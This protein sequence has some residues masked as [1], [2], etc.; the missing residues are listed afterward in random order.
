LPFVINMNVQICP[1]IGWKTD[2]PFGGNIRLF[3]CIT[4]WKSNNNFVG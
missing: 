4:F 3:F 2:D 1:S